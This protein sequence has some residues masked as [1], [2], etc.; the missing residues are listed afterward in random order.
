LRVL[1]GLILLTG[2]ISCNRNKVFTQPNSAMEPTILSGEKFTAE[3][4]PFQPLRGDLVI[5][6]HEG[7]LIVKR[8]IA[9]GGDVVEGRDLKVLLNGR[10]LDEPYI[11]HIGNP[12]DLMSQVTFGPVTVSPGSI[13][14]AGDNRDYSFDSRAPRF[15]LVPIADVTGKPLKIVDS[16]NPKRML[17]PVQ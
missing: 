7:V 5:F 8:V 3:M 10:L 2:A 11:E 16:S 13:F 6:H 12:S 17:T 14:V 1:V 4:K 15:G 9:V